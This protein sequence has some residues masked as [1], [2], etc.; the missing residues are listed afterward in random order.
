MWET[1]HGF[2]SGHTH[3]KGTACLDCLPHWL[4][5]RWL[6]CTANEC[7]SLRYS[8]T[9]TIFKEFYPKQR[10]VFLWKGLCRVYAVY[11]AWEFL[12]SPVNACTFLVSRSVFLY[13]E[14]RAACLPGVSTAVLG[15]PWW[16]LSIVL[17]L[18]SDKGPEEPSVVLPDGSST[19]MLS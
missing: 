4:L 15:S 8:V 7:V 19:Q 10:T 11:Y 9:V 1:R 3:W 14:K 18:S 16:S 17:S 2:K 6:L 13:L 5:Y 12:S